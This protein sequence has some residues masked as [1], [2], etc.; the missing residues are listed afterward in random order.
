MAIEA[1]AAFVT[2]MERAL[3]T[4]LTPDDMTSTSQTKRR[5]V[6]PTGRLTVYARCSTFTSTGCR[7]KD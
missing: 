6:S 5:E 3:S 4:V 7:E 1:K 2:R